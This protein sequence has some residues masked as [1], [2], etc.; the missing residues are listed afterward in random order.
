MKRN[1]ILLGVI[2]A[3]LVI[4]VAAAVFIASSQRAGVGDI[5]TDDVETMIF[6]AEMP[7]IQYADENK[8]IIFGDVGLIAYDMEK[9]EITNRLSLGEI[10]KLGYEMPLCHVSSDGKKAYFSPGM[11]D[12]C[13]YLYE[14]D[15]SSGRLKK[16]SSANR[17]F[18]M[19]VKDS[20]EIMSSDALKRIDGDG[21]IFS[22]LMV[23][24]KDGEYLGIGINAD[25]KMN[26]L[27]AVVFDS[28]GNRIKTCKIFD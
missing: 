2:A 4:A 17:E 13:E 14:Y 27:Q 19:G 8:V 10:K 5:N 18:F 3:V 22:S 23:E 25:G 6:G 20:T 24:I 1:K 7:A 9:S 11:I 15:F 12:A 16:I 21:D 28:E 26:T